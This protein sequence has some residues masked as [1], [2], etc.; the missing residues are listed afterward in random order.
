MFVRIGLLCLAA[1]F[2]GLGIES[3][4]DRS[5]NSPPILIA[6]G[7]LIGLGAFLV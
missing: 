3:T 4:I 5:K 1:L 7:A 6:L 2:V